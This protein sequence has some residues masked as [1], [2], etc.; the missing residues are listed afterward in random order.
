MLLH[1]EN[2][3]F[4]GEVTMQVQC[5][6]G[7]KILFLEGFTLYKQKYTQCTIWFLR[8]PDCSTDRVLVGMKLKLLVPFCSTC[9]VVKVSSSQFQEI[10]ASKF[11]FLHLD[12]GDAGACSPNMYHGHVTY[13]PIHVSQILQITFNE[14]VC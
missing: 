2:L 6:T 9:Q 1:S 10:V 7:Q 4:S 11:L 8:L 14:S 12:L 13:N 3:T 5:S